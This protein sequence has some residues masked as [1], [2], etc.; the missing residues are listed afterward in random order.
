M[1]AIFR[2]ESV[3]NFLT[4]VFYLRA[5]PA[6]ICVPFLF[7]EEKLNFLKDLR[8]AGIMY[9]RSACISVNQCSIFKGVI[10]S[11]RHTTA[12][13]NLRLASSL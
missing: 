11:L 8:V 6:L 10:M 4:I 12:N 13:E 5:Q 9:L 1:G 3:T 7:S 2:G